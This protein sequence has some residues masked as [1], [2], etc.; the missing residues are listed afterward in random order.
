[1]QQHF[2]EKNL[3]VRQ[4]WV[5]VKF[6]SPGPEPRKRCQNCS[7][8]H[9]WYQSAVGGTEEEGA[10]TK[11]VQGKDRQ[12]YGGVSLCPACLQRVYPLD[13]VSRGNYSDIHQ[14]KKKKNGSVNISY[15]WQILYFFISA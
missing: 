8:S 13:R 12:A 4:N 9:L 5:N 1:M 2:T 10:E 11:M 6:C 7:P 14:A 15:Y 3:E